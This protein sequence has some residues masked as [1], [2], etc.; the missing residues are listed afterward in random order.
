M[1]LFDPE[2]PPFL[3]LT[4]REGTL[5]VS[6]IRSRFPVADVSAGLLHLW[7]DHWDEAHEIAQSCEGERDHDMLHGILHRKEGDF[8]NAAY[9][10]RRAGRHPCFPL[11]AEGVTALSA[12][13]GHPVPAFAHKA[14]DPAGFVQAV[15]TPAARPGESFLRAV[16]AVEIMT[17]HSWLQ[18]HGSP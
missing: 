1:S 18:P 9:W 13:R 16:Q 15:R 10:F 8:S 11:I 14:W 7:H 5:S 4:R 3:T 17:F 6:E 12:R 2:N